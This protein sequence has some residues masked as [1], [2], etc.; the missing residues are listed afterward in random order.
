VENLIREMEFRQLRDRLSLWDL[1]KRYPRRR[2]VARVRLA[3]ERLK[4]EPAGR[5]RSPLEERFAPFLRQRHLPLPRFNDTI[6][7]GNKRYEV[8]CHW[9]GTGEIVELD[10]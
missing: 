10:G 9:P 7:L 1:V 3:L 5:K 8:D 6:V 2:G 4:E